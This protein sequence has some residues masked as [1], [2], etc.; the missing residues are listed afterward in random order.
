MLF[1]SSTFLVFFLLVFILY[2]LLQKKLVWQNLLLYISSLVFYG[3]W[4]WRFLFLIFF[5]AC[6]DYVVGIL[7]ADEQ[8]ERKRKWLLIASLVVNLGTLG[9]FKYYNFFAESFVELANL[10]GYHPGNV[11]LNIILPVGI[12]FYTFQTMSYSIDIYRRKFK[13]TRNFLNFFTYVAFFPQ[14]VAGPIERAADLLPQIERPR[15]FRTVWF[16]E[17]IVQICVGF[18][19]KIVVADNLGIYV[20]NIYANP[21]LHNSTTLMLAAVFFTFQIYC[22]FAGYSDIAIGTAKL[23]GFRFQRNFD[24][25]FFSRTLSEHWRRWHM[26]LSYW[27]RDYVYIPLGGNRKGFALQARNLF[28]TMFLCGLWHLNTANF[29]I[30]GAVN[31][32]W[33]VVEKAVQTT[34]QQNIKRWKL[35]AWVRVMITFAVFTLSLIFFRQ[36]TLHDSTIVMSR[37]LNFD[38]G[39][40]SITNVN[41]F[42]KIILVF[43]L[44]N[45]IDVLLY[46]KK[47]SLEHAGRYFP[48]YMIVLCVAV[49]VLLCSLFFSGTTN[50]IYFQF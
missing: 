21:D 37:I 26:S 6:V 22:D 25:P 7:I 40:P 1:T 19:R 2:W 38:L 49:T 39:M 46:K 9:F 42:A 11:T 14:L 41:L 16:K 3:W 43:V 35:Y 13:P 17:G 5:S 24:L 8:N 34:D 31:G 36:A 12:S 50:F 30:F 20:D 27:M 47:L 45:V 48:N 28:L 10:F 23:L 29:M 44:V 15:R 4:D 33:V 18:I 32:I